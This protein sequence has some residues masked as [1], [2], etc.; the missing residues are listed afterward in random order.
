MRLAMGSSRTWLVRAAIS[1]GLLLYAVL[2]TVSAFDRSARKHPGLAD[3]VPS[4]LQAAAPAARARRF[5]EAGL[6]APALDPALAALQADPV[7]PASTALYATALLARGAQRQADSAFRVGARLGWREPLTQLYWMETA[8]AANDMRAA[9][10]RFDALARQYPDAPAMAQAATRL[11]ASAAG[12]AA[13]AARMAQGASW[14]GSY[15][16]IDG[17]AGADRVLARSDVLA[18]AARLGLKLGCEPIARITRALA[19]VDPLRGAAL[20]REHCADA[21][22][23]GAIADSGF[24]RFVPTRQRVPFEWALAGHG[25]LSAVIVPA[26]SAGNGQALKL[27][28]SGAAT[29]P[30]LMQLVPL[31]PGRYRIGWTGASDE[32]LRTELSCASQPAVPPVAAGA[33]QIF[34][35]DASCPARWLRFWLTPG[36]TSVLFDEVVL[37]RL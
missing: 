4:A 22:T 20:W 7:D 12:R 27:A 23:A 28:N 2:A 26:D 36:A 6:P 31:P 25:D 21:G 33:G 32:R 24:E 17:R 16:Q 19:A 14:A 29:I 35:V 1:G 37:E 11:E 9:V 18:A 13:L 10:L 30:V 8:L 15:A 3:W 34:E 5:I